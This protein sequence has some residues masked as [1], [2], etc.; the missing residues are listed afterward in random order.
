MFNKKKK[1]MLAISASLRSA[2]VSLPTW[3]NR[4]TGPP[5]QATYIQFSWK[6]LFLVTEFNNNTNNNNNNKLFR[7][8][9]SNLKTKCCFIHSSL[10]GSL[11]PLTRLFKKLLLDS[12]SGGLPI[13]WLLPTIPRQR[14]NMLQQAGDLWA[15]WTKNQL[16]SVLTSVRIC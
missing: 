4:I 5:R 10:H 13:F 12:F 7:I 15:Y 11:S 1:K 9:I 2:S 6:V 16:N 8:I 14:R 3:F